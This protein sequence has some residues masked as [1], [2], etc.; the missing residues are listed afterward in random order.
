MRYQLFHLGYYNKKS[1]FFENWFLIAKNIDENC[2]INVCLSSI[3]E[4]KPTNKTFEYPANIDTSM[5][6]A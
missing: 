1:I 5:F 3:F 4:L 2:L 6:Y